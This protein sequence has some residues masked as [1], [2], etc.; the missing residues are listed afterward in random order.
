MAA[1][2]V[3]DPAVGAP[4][5]PSPCADVGVAGDAV[6]LAR[7]FCSGDSGWLAI[8]NEPQPSS[9]ATG[10][11]LPPDFSG[12]IS[13]SGNYRGTVSSNGR[14]SA[15]GELSDVLGDMLGA[16][17]THIGGTYDVELIFDP[18]G[19]VRGRASGSGQA[20]PV[21]LIGIRSGSQ[22]RLF[23][24][25]D[26]GVIE[27]N[28]TRSRFSGLQTSAPSQARRSRR[29]NLNLTATQV[30]ETRTETE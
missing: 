13:Y 10:D 12:S 28:C 7:L 16:N 9:D 6:R 15:L 23:T 30:V 4:H 22:C 3:V 29:V 14:G 20:P 5:R 24:S 25:P 21:T 18:D 27:G 2:V 17:A 11:I 19:Q 8:D 26:A 1:I